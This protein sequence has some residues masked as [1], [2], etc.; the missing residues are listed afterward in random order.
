MPLPLLPGLGRGLVCLLHDEGLRASA[1]EYVCYARVVHG[2][3][4]MWTWV[5][6]RAGDRKRIT[7]RELL[8]PTMTLRLVSNSYLE[9]S[10]AKIR[11]K[12]VPWEVCSSTLPPLT[13]SHSNDPPIGISTRW[14]YHSRGARAYQEGRQTAQ[15][16]D[17][18]PLAL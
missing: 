1:S 11:V 13:S 8:Q 9:E 14:T 15:V 6:N 16:K 4:R 3:R 7:R 5:K 2:I 17:R 10:T 12:Q 18:V